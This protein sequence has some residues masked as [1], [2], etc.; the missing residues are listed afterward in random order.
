MNSHG[1]IGAK[2]ADKSKFVRAPLPQNLELQL[3]VKIAIQQI[4]D[5]VDIPGLLDISHSMMPTPSAR[6]TDIVLDH[7]ATASLM[8]VTDFLQL[9]GGKSN[10]SVDD[11]ITEF[12]NVMQVE[13]DQLDPQGVRS[14]FLY[15]LAFK[16]CE[17]KDGKISISSEA[18]QLGLRINEFSDVLKKQQQEAMITPDNLLAA[19]L[20][21]G[22]TSIQILTKPLGN[23]KLSSEA[24]LALL[25]CPQSSLAHILENLANCSPSRVQDPLL[26]H[27]SAAALSTAVNLGI[28]DTL[29]LATQHQD[30]GLTV[31][32][33][34]DKMMLSTHIPA[35]SGK[36]VTPKTLRY[37]LDNLV[38]VG[39]LKLNDNKYHIQQSYSN[40]LIKENISKTNDSSK[41]GYIQLLK[42]TKAE[43]TIRNHLI[44]S[45]REK[46]NLMLAEILNEDV[47]RFLAEGMHCL[48]KE[49]AKQLR[50]SE[51]LS[52][53]LRECM[54]KGHINQ[55]LL[56][57][58]PGSGVVP[59]SIAAD[60]TWINEIDYYDI[61][62][63]VAKSK[64]S[65]VIKD[66]LQEKEKDTV[67]R[68]TTNQTFRFRKFDFFKE[69]IPP[70]PAGTIIE[71]G[72][73]LHDWTPEQNVELLKN[74]NAA[75]PDGGGILLTEKFLPK[76]VDKSPLNVTNFNG[77]M[78]AWTRGQQYSLV[79]LGIWFKKAGKSSI[80]IAKIDKGEDYMHS[81]MI[82]V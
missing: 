81:V 58:G 35:L 13:I 49:H 50:T 48:S 12:S 8:A 3:S 21:A 2:L 15:L 67:F 11:F 55:K 53:I 69:K 5:H 54:I 9:I 17:I 80:E 73:V 39:F 43:Q 38:A 79:D 18:Q 42:G 51:E 82:K 47:S 74:I 60:R 75:L 45:Q 28:F 26:R 19:L 59:T 4:I 24:M 64:L 56:S 14:I 68:P 61:Q 16:L 23:A 37:L 66:E 40:Y 77:A 65:Y 30:V 32:Q 62:P 27:I 57:L 46:D 25:V 78:Q 36:K 20:S 41:V 22:D 1:M 63:S 52:D 33:L 6:I 44:A 10:L 34:S 76:E 29:F 31:E 71:L 7:T 70:Q 72:N